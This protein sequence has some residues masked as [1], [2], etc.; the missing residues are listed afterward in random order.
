MAA[1]EHPR[2]AVET[3]IGRLYAKHGELERVGRGRYCYKTAPTDE[4]ALNG[5]GSA[6]P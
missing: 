3:A 1:I 2:K 5:N 4:T 6:E